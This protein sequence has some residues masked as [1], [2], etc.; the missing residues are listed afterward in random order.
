MMALIDGDLA[1]TSSLEPSDPAVNVPA[2]SP[3]MQFRTERD[4]FQEALEYEHGRM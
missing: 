2:V 1:T 4:C 3:F